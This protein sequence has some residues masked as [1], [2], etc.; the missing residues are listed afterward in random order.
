MITTGKHPYRFTPDHLF[1]ATLA[2]G[3]PG[4]YWPR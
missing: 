1:K 4:P 3:R 2:K